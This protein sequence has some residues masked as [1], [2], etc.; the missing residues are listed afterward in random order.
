MFLSGTCQC[1]RRV[2][3]ELRVA[4]LFV[5]SSARRCRPTSQ[6]QQQQQQQHR[7][8]TPADKRKRRTVLMMRVSREVQCR[9]TLGRTLNETELMTGRERMQ[10]GRARRTDGGTA[11]TAVRP[12]GRAGDRRLEYGRTDWGE[13]AGTSPPPRLV[14][15]RSLS[16]DDGQRSRERRAV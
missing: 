9:T 7:T 4:K 16:I 12:A 13:S 1:Q 15:G 8:R 2:D 10:T 3:D 11:L 6:H 14:S 5:E